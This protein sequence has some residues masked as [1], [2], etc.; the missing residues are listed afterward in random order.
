MN[1]PLTHPLGDDQNVL[2]SLIMHLPKVELHLHL[3]GTLEPELMVTLAERNGVPLKYKSVDAVRNAYHFGNL[4]SF[5][6]IYY[7]ACSV[8]LHEQDFYDLTMAYLQR[9]HAQHI[10][11][12]EMFFDPQTHTQRG[13]SFATVVSGTRRAMVDGERAYGITSHLI[14]CF[15]R[16]L[17][18]EAAF[19]T[20]EQALPYREHIIAV[21]LDSYE[22]GNPPSRFADVFERARQHGFLTVAHAGEEG[23]AEYIWQALN[24]L[25]VSRLDHGVR[26]L[27]DEALVR[28][29]VG[30]QVPLT[31]CPFSNVKLGVFGRLED[32]NLRQMLRRGLCVTVNSDDPA[33]FGGYLAEN[34]V[35]AQQALHLT[36]D[37]IYQL[38]RNAI[39]AAFLHDARKQVLL[40]KAAAVFHQQIAS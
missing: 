20:L 2:V 8:L 19:D 25:H 13:V 1:Q 30:R 18:A 33:Y 11:H 26:C 38:A 12:T 24:L 4:Q 36:A 21:G 6:D 29:L 3:E 40:D 22:V 10:L 23:P 5:L 27:D 16:H 14:M 35:A 32:H 15:L 31:V 37:E 9:A 17:N 39:R 7:E 34:F 28:E